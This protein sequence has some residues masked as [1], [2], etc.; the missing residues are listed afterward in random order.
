MI[1]IIDDREVGEFISRP[2]VMDVPNTLMNPF[3][4]FLS[5]HLKC[6]SPSQ[7]KL[8][9]RGFALPMAL[10]VGLVLMVMSLA[11]VGRSQMGAQNTV[12]QKTTAEGLAIAETGITRILDLINQNR[13][14]SMFPDCV[15]RNSSGQ[16]QDPSVMSSPKPQSWAT[17]NTIS[18]ISACGTAI[19]STQ[20]SPLVASQSWFPVNSS[21]ADQGEY[22]LI[23]YQY[24][25]TVGIAPGTATLTME[26]RV[27]NS[28]QLNNSNS[29]LEVQIPVDASPP[30][31]TGVPGVWLTDGGTGN[32]TI[33]GDVLLGDCGTSPGNISIT[34]TDPITSQPYTAKYTSLE[35]PDLPTIPTTNINTLNNP[36]GNINLPRGTDLSTTET[37]AGQ[38]ITFYRYRVNEIDFHSG[39]NNITIAP[40]PNQRVLF[41]LNGSIDVGANSD[42]VHKCTNSSNQPIAG[43]KPTD[44]QIFGYSVA[45]S[46]RA[47]ICMSGNNRLD[48]FILAP[49]YTIGI[50]GSGG[51]VGGIKGTVWAYDWSNSGGCGSNTSNVVVYQQ[52]RWDDLGLQPKNVPPTLRN[53][54]SWQRKQR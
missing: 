34:G 37:I 27:N 30:L 43:C 54:S 53:I 42:I 2:W 41:Y 23:N 19:N 20:I 35:F 48:A 21:N 13:Y 46:P 4:F 6:Y 5:S 14:I 24:S 9:S 17:V 50:A 39:T 32:N 51:G 11:M 12:S 28:N 47:Q 16:C 3:I 22:R 52:A 7:P 49:A 18:E 15:T 26:G 33:Q 45:T 1:Q 38:T 10:M 8:S 36:S 44:F 31:T 29:R 25:P 40:T